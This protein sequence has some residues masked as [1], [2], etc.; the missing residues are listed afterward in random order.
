M[1]QRKSNTKEQEDL[2]RGADSV[3]AAETSRT[4]SQL[5]A[6]HTPAPWRLWLSEGDHGAFM[7]HGD[8]LD[9]H[10]VN[11]L[12]TQRGIGTPNGDEGVANAHLIAAAPDLL[13]AL[14]EALELVDDL[15]LTYPAAYRDYIGY[16]KIDEGWRAVIAK[17]E[18]R[19]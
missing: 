8:S 4:A 19:S 2:T 13:A 5:R 15:R 9:P 11:M 7:L 14:K 18:G 3:V 12:I 17:T 10:G 16:T 6:S 1:A